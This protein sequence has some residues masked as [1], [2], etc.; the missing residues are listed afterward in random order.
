MDRLTDTYYR[1]AD[2]HDVYYNDIV[3]RHDVV[4]PFFDAMWVYVSPM[5][6]V[7]CIYIMDPHDLGYITL[8]SVKKLFYGPM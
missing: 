3:V 1:F 7:H 5:E 8:D 4:H 6:I 2:T